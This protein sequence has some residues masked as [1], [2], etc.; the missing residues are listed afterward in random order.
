MFRSNITSCG[1]F[2]VNENATRFAPNCRQAML[3]IVMCSSISFSLH[4]D[5]LSL[6]GFSDHDLLLY[7]CH[8]NQCTPADIIYFRDFNAIDHIQLS[9]ECSITNWNDCWHLPN[10]NDKLESLTKN[11][12]KVFNNNVPFKRVKVQKSKPPWYNHEVKR[13]KK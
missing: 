3:D 11:I 9:N 2:V 8:F 10:V 13:R 7:A 5:Q 12:L 4:F 1:L 6:E